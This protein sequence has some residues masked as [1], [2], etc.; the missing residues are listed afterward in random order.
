MGSRPFASSSGGDMKTR[1]KSRPGPVV[2]AVLSAL[3]FLTPVA[4]ADFQIDFGGFGSGL[5]APAILGS[6]V[7]ITD[8]GIGIFDLTRAN[9]NRPSSKGFA[10]FEIVFSAPQVALGTGGM[11]L[12]IANSNG[13]AALLL[14][15]VTLWPL[16]LT[17]HGIHLLVAT[18]GTSDP[19]RTQDVEPPMPESAGLHRVLLRPTLFVAQRGTAPGL[20]LGFQF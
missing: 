9:A 20:S 14:G 1:M 12:A 8:V 19:I 2:A 3:I 6:V 4:K 16:A 13:V 17:I 5:A 11:V 15:I 7:L 10:I 18:Q